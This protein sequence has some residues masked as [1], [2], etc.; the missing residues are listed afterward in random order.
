[1]LYDRLYTLENVSAMGDEHVN[2]LNEQSRTEIKGAVVEPSLEAAEGGEKF[3]FVRF[4]FF[5]K[6]T[7]NE[8]TFNQ[9]VSMKD[10]AKK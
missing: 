3:Q 6:D 10:N 4:G 1:M 2:Y 9:V 8:N 7:K 5:C